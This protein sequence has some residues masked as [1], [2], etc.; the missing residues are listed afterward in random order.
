MFLEGCM[1]GYIGVFQ[2]KKLVSENII[3]FKIYFESQSNQ[4]QSK[5]DKNNKLQCLFS[6]SFSALVPTISFF[7]GDGGG[8]EG[9]ETGGWIASPPNFYIL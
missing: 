1:Y 9:G 8:G 2:I 3:Q 7:W 4:N 5:L 6:L